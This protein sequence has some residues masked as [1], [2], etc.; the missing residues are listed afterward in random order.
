MSETEPSPW[1]V[2]VTG[3]SGFIGANLVKR[4]VAEGHEVHIIVREGSRTHL[5]A[6]ELATVTVHV[7]DGSTRGMLDIVGAARPHTVFHLAS[8]FLAQH[9]ASDVEALINSNV[10]FST[11]LVEAMAAHGVPYLINTGT[12]WQHYENQDHN[13]VNLY[14]ATKQAFEAI[15]NYYI[16]AQG[17]KVS[18]LI[19]FDTYGPHD[20]R[21]KLIALLW[22]TALT[23]QPI[24][25]SPGEQQIDLVH[26][27]DVIE[28]FVMAARL[29]PNQV[30]GH[31]RYGVSS[32]RPMPLKALVAAFEQAT[33]LS[34]PI[35]WGG[36]PYRPREVMTTWSRHDS[37]PGWQARIPFETG[38]LMTRPAAD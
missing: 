15:L 16:E 35:T 33:G 32:G 1:R 13:P 9:T 10:L 29:L 3:A 26:I 20:P 17:L 21:A 34:L 5:I 6:P 24:S 2:L 23:Q 8:L 19:L 11:Q 7:H 4:L 22:K 31:R 27:D 18:S 25:M 36:R 30:Q 14:A 37:V 28:A 38:V 12:S